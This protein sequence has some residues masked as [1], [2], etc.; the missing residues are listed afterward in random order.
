MRVGPFLSIEQAALSHV[1][2]G[3][4]GQ[5]CLPGTRWLAHWRPHSVRYVWRDSAHEL[6]KTTMRPV[7]SYRVV[8]ILCAALGACLAFLFTRA[9]RLLQSEFTGEDFCLSRRL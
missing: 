3:G 9:F 4:P 7:G 8:V 1:I 2:P 5:R 6:Q